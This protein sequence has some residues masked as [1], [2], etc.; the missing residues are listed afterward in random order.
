M[1]VFAVPQGLLGAFEGQMN[2]GWKRFGIRC[3]LV[4]PRGDSSVIRSRVSEGGASQPAPGRVTEVAFPPELVEHSAVI[5]WIDQ[6][7]YV[8]MVFRR[9]P[10]HGRAADVDQLD[11]GIAAE[12]IEIA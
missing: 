4:E 3:R 10:H 8:R 12:R 7:G 5:R 2:A 1:R 9:R 6:N 11:R